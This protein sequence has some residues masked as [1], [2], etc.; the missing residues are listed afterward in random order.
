M[1]AEHLNTVPSVYP[2][3][4]SMIGRVGLVVP[5]W[6]APDTSPQLAREL[7]HAT[8]GDLPS[9]LA[10]A[11]ALVVVDGS[12]VAAAA[13]RAVLAGLSAGG[14][15]PFRIHELPENQGK[16]A[17]LA[18]GIRLLLEERPQLT[19]IAIRDADGDHFLDDLPH[20][21]RA[22]EQVREAYPDR[23]VWVVGRRSSVHAPLGWIRGEYELLLNEV[24]VEA[25]AFARARAG[26]VWDTRF[27]IDRVPDLQSGYKL[28]T[29]EA[30]RLSL[31][32][33]ATE[34]TAYPDLDLGRTGMEIVPF[35]ALALN[36]GICVEGERKTFFDQP[37]SSYGRADRAAFYGS[38]LAWALLKCEL[39][40]EA[41]ARLL[42]G[43]LARRPLFTDPA[44]REEL[45]RFREA[46]LQRLD[47][48]YDATPPLTRLYL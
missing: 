17:A 27:L 29:A 39:P 2:L 22:G 46:V 5:A 19:W 16:G 32:A 18:L 44:G 14:A 36:G 3:R 48:G 34:A 12:P 4:E 20:L 8:L 30:A 40:A 15:P 26:R 33:I 35:V 31:K 41:S 43:A 42:D 7:L 45:L 38:K 47:P 9:C 37:V 13:A 28:Y 21:Y 24:I 25:V 10:P 23:P 11:D 1:I 6:F